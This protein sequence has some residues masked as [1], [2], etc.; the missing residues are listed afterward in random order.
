MRHYEGLFLFASRENKPDFAGIE[1]HVGEVLAKHG[2]KIVKTQKWAERKLAYEV[3]KS[4]RGAY[5]LV[6][7]D[8]EPTVIP[9]IRRDFQIS[10]RILRF[11]IR[12]CEEIPQELPEIMEF[13]EEPMGFDADSRGRGGYR[14]GRDRDDRPGYRSRR[15]EESGAGGGG[16][17]VGSRPAMSSREGSGP[18]T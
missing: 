11:L 3:K 14:G 13:R 5:L 6:Y 10:E 18:Q 12:A 8:A 7:L 15:S 16:E 17:T 2:A 4:R 1:Q 9:E